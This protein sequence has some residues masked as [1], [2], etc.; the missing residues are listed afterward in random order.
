MS[1]DKR[2]D[3]LVLASKLNDAELENEEL[4]LTLMQKGVA[5]K[6]MTKTI[7]NLE[8][9]VKSLET[10]KTLVLQTNE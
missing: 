9:Q 8:K 6:A 10:E 3:K 7:L 4:R 5:L 2:A 1:A